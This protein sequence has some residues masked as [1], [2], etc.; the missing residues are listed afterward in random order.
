[1]ELRIINRTAAGI[2]AE[3]EVSGN[4]PEREAEQDFLDLL[5]R[6]VRADQKS[7]PRN[8]SLHIV[9][10]TPGLSKIEINLPRIP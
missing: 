9:T 10:E 8:Q 2:V 6:H 1:M 3:I 7:L 4:R 5:L